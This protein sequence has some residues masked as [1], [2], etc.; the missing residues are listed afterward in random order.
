MF[1][2]LYVV[3]LVFFVKFYGVEYIKDT[4][5]GI[6]FIIIAM[7]GLYIS[8]ELSLIP[9]KRRARK[10]LAHLTGRA[11]GRITNHREERIDVRDENDNWKSEYKGTIIYYEFEVGGQTYTGSGYG[12]WS[13]GKKEHQTICYDPANPSDNLPLAEVNS[14]TKTHILG[15]LLYLAICFGL[16]FGI[17]FFFAWLINR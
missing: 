15:T 5:S 11:E 3:A 1:F 9:E 14:K 10:K 7:V 12:S 2:L 8:V 16:L 17:I 13:L 6:I 4:K